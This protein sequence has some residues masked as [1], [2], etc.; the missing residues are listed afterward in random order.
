MR[1]QSLQPGG[2]CLEESIFLKVLEKLCEAKWKDFLNG[3]SVGLGLADLGCEGEEE[4]L[5]YIALN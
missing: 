3:L 1:K 4:A 5:A 2:D